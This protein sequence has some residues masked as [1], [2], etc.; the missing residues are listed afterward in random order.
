MA[1]Q[2]SPVTLLFA[3]RQPGT[4][5][6]AMHGRRMSGTLLGVALTWLGLGMGSGSAQADFLSSLIANHQSVQ[7][8]NLVFDQFSYSPTGQMPLAT[9]VTV[10]PIVDINGN[11]G[12]R[13]GGGF[14]D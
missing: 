4:D 8:G 3:D 12:L 11:P 1:G 6:K 5:I 2:G 13:F 9:N 14:T 7:V 10:N